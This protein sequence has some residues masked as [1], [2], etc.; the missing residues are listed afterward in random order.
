MVLISS[1][2]QLYCMC[3]YYRFIYGS[4]FRVLGKGVFAQHLHF[5]YAGYIN[6][7]I[8]TYMFPMNIVSEGTY[9][10]NLACVFENEY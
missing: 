1:T 3:F 6:C 8:G 2:K 10:L 5:I 7:N 4:F 9:A